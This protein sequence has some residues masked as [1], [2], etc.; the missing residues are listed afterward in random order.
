MDPTTC[1][2]V[3]NVSETSGGGVCNRRTQGTWI[4]C[5]FI[6]NEAKGGSPANGGG[7]LFNASSSPTLTDCE[8]YQNSAVSGGGG[9]WNEKDFEGDPPVL[10]SSPLLTD[11]DFVENSAGS[12]SGTG[13]G[14]MWN[15]DSS[16]PSVV[17]C[18]FR[19]NQVADGLIYGGAMWNQDAGTQPLISGCVFVQG[20]RA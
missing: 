8:F 2:F 5:K 7:G 6:G 17:G 4:N 10:P 14:G 1:N 11:C 15:Q 18:T 12:S 3:G 20:Q 13:G 9:I 19:G 16:S